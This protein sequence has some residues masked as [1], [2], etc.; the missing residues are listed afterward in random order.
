M[1]SWASSILGLHAGARITKRRTYKGRRNLKRLNYTDKIRIKVPRGKNNR[2]EAKWKPILASLLRY[3]DDGFCLSKINFENSYGFTVNG[4]N[5]RVKHA[6]QALNVF[7]HLVLNVESIG[8]NVNTGLSDSLAY[9]AD[10]Y[11][12]TP[13]ELPYGQSQR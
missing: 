3:V 9:Q 2:T 13:A 11:I 7:H 6:V 10:S 4:I 12:R 1:V 5:H 8:M